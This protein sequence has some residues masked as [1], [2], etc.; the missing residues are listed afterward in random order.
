MLMSNHNQFPSFYENK[1]WDKI[2]TIFQRCFCPDQLPQKLEQF[3][4][5]P[6][7]VSPATTPTEEAKQKE[8]EKCAKVGL[9]AK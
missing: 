2:T 7:P 3:T 1:I 5:P 6:E 4:Y 9:E 8:L